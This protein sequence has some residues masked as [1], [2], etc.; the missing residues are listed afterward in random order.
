L[1]EYSTAEHRRQLEF[2]HDNEDIGKVFIG[3]AGMGTKKINIAS[4]LSEVKENEIRAC[5]SGYGEV[6]SIRDE[7]WTSH[8]DTMFTVE[9]IELK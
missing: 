5:L 9:Y 4:L 6:K 1:H 8:I 3:I 2:R 7:V